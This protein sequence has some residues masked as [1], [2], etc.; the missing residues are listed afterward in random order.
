M[1]PWPSQ[2]GADIKS[3]QTIMGHAKAQTT[4]DIY[5]DATSEAMRKTADL[6]AG[7][8]RAPSVSSFT[9]RRETAPREARPQG[10]ASRHSWRRS[11]QPSSS[12]VSGMTIRVVIVVEAA[13]KP[14]PLIPLADMLLH[15]LQ[16]QHKPEPPQISPH[17]LRHPILI[18]HT[19]D[20][21]NLPHPMSSKLNRPVTSAEP[22]NAPSD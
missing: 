15:R 5:A 19:Q 14:H 3:V 1:R 7:A 22:Y 17:M 8:L 20:Q 13:L 9:T 10:N 21:P 16:R 6:T 12:H 4:L 2:R 11:V 18:I